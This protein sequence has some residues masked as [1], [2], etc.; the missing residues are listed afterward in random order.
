[1]QKNLKKFEK[2]SS[3]FKPFS[4][5]CVLMILQ[6]QTSVLLTIERWFG[7]WFSLGLG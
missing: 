4:Q 6:E 5:Q 7:F 3:F 2:K 1:V